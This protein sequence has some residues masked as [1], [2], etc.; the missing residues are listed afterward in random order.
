MRLDISGN[1]TID[2]PT[3]VR[4]EQVL[5]GMLAAGESYVSLDAGEQD[6]VMALPSEFQGD[7]YDL[8]F[9]EGSAD[10]HY[11]AGDSRPVDEVVEVFLSYL[12]GDNV[13]RTRVEW[14]RVDQS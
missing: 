7:F 2:G 8:E 10:R 11:E 5:R 9:R 3:P 12:R 1:T 6:Y 13:W 4:V 14:K